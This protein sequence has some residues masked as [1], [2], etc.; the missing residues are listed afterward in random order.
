ML[1]YVTYIQEIGA[2]IMPHL[3]D[4]EIKA[5]KDCSIWSTLGQGQALNTPAVWFQN[6]NSQKKKKKPTML[7][8]REVEPKAY[9]GSGLSSASSYMT[10]GKVISAV[11][12]QFHQLGKNIRVDDTR[13][14]HCSNI[15]WFYMEYTEP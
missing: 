7:L 9:P 6:Q 8:I 1:L 4:E 12:P 10:L 3:P 15:E 13:F 2:I 14:S 11:W 5:Q